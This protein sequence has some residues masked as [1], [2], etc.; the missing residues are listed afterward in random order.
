MKRYIDHCESFDDTRIDK[1]RRLNSDYVWRRDLQ[2]TFLLPLIIFIILGLE[3]YFGIISWCEEFGIF[4]FC[5]FLYG[6]C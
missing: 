3:N 6:A 5:H 1:I 4:C 2:E